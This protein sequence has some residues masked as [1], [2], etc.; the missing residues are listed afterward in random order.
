MIHIFIINSHAGNSSFSAELRN[1][2]A[3]RIDIN[4][5][6]LHTRKS[7]TETELVREVISLFEGEKI[8]IYSCG[9]SGTFCNI[10][11]GISDFS[12]IELAFFP[13]GLT[14]DFLE[15]FGKQEEL[16]NDI[17]ALIDGDV[18]NIDYIK[19]NHGVAL[20]TFSL[21]LDSLQIRKTEEFRPLSIF[22]RD[23]P[24]NLATIIS[25]LFCKPIDLEI[26]IDGQIQIGRFA[27]VFFGNGGLLGG[28]LYCDLDMNYMDGKGFFCLKKFISRRG[29]FKTLHGLQISKPDRKTYLDYEALVDKEITIRRR[30]GAKFEVDL[31]G[32]IQE[33]QFEWTVKIEK[34]A[35][36][37]VVPKGLEV[38][39]EN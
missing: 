3:S 35:L 7:R 15:A 13:N 4:Y 9:G 37:F 28:I 18:V 11:N 14:N 10:L 34:Q 1:H 2:L 38:R 5:Y 26:E 32:E 31:D 17:D 8:R 27:E 39:C 20:N 16:F 29:L 24:Y 25:V 19:T 6:I 30:D 12:K 23:V 36:P 22:G 33:P 21:G